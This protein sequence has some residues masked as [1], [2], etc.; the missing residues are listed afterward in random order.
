MSNGVDPSNNV[1]YVV[2]G[3]PDSGESTVPIPGMGSASI[4]TP[5]SSPSRESSSVPQPAA[6]RRVLDLPFDN[7]AATGKPIHCS[8]RV[9]T[10]K[11]NILDFIPLNL[12]EQFSKTA[13]VYFLIQ[14]ILV[15]FPQISPYI[16]YSTVSPFAFVLTMSAAKDAYTDW[17]RHM[18]DDATN[19][20]PALVLRDGH[21]TNV[22][23]REINVGD[24]LQIKESELVPADMLVL[25][26]Q[27]L[28]LEE[29]QQESGSANEAGVCF[30]DTAA[31]DG[32]TNLKSYGGIAETAHLRTAEAL[33][34]M[35][36]EL[37]T[38]A[39]N[40]SLYT[41]DGV[42]KLGHTEH[43]LEKENVLLRGMKVKNTEL[44][45][46]VAI[47]TG[48]DSKI[49]KNV[50]CPLLFDDKVEGVFCRMSANPALRSQIWTA[51]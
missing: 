11:Y 2:E 7:L 9:V 40:G 14:S 8:N 48:T 15:F 32:E 34:C 17:Y 33:R 31:L 24:Y 46:G 42:L 29:G 19:D 30:V 4:R 21:W 27:L 37:S 47:F 10:A 26:T 36:A 49:V 6:E 51:R 45:W 39:P 22:K 3:L 38:E 16:W 12:A 44:V 35:Q 25:A 28:K 41:F 18:D 13:N 1:D 43:H 5:E 50:S 20:Q 23:W